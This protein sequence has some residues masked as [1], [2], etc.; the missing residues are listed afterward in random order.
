M[1][2]KRVEEMRTTEPPVKAL[3]QMDGEQHKANRAIINDWFKPGSVQQMQARVDELAKHYVD[4]MATLGGR[5]DFAQDIAVHYPAAGD[6][7]DPGA[8]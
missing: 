3:V 1:D 8:P 4:E 6:P 7:L 5:C 2:E